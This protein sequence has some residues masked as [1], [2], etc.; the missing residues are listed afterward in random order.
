MILRPSFHPSS[1]SRWRNAAVHSLC[2]G[3]ASEPSNP[4][5]GTG[6]CCARGAEAHVTAAPLN[7]A[8]NSRRLMPD[9]GFF[10]R[11]GDLVTARNALTQCS[12]SESFDR[13]ISRD[14]HSQRH[15]ETERLCGLEIDDKLEHGRLRDR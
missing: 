4:M 1:R 10:S 14:L 2:A 3:A 9:L 13:L 7:S 11:I 6:D 8:M 5:T 12:N 15:S